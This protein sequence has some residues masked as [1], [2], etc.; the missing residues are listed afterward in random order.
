MFDRAS[1]S[2]PGAGARVLAALV[3][4]VHALPAYRLY[5]QQCVR[6][7]H[8]DP[9]DWKPDER[10]LLPIYVVQLYEDLDKRGYFVRAFG[11][12]CKCGAIPRSVRPA[13]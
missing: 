8:R 4:Q 6:E 5:Y 1:D 7:Q 2:S 10:D 13:P 9:D 3:E 12:S 11:G